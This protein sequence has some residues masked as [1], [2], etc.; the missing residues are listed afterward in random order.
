LNYGTY[1]YSG[2]YYQS[3]Y[4]YGGHGYYGGVCVTVRKTPTGYGLLLPNGNWYPIA[5]SV[6]ETFAKNWSAA[7]AALIKTP[8][9]S[10]SIALPAGGKVAVTL[11]R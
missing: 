1:F 3:T 5:Q 6:A 8:N 11:K 7:S 9:V 2:V 10:G 4:L